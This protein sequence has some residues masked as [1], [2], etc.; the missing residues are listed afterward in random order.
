MIIKDF[1]KKLVFNSK[2]RLKFYYMIEKLSAD[3]VE[4][5]FY[6]IL[7]ELQQAELENN[8]NRKTLLYY[9][10]E[11]FIGWARS[12]KTIAECLQDYV[13]ETDVMMI[14]AFEEHDI[15]QGFRDLIAYNE[16]LLGMKKE[17]VAAIAYPAFLVVILIAIMAY[18]SIS[19]IPTLTQNMPESIQLSGVSQVLVLLSK[20]FFI[21]F[22]AICFFILFIIGFLLWALPNFNSALRVKLEGIPP[23]N[24]YR[25]NIGCGFLQSL[26]MLTKSGMQQAEAIETMAKLAAPY[27]AYRLGVIYSKVR[28]GRSLGEALVLS[29]L[30]F[31]DKKMVSDLSILSKHGVLENSLDKLADTM[32]R[33]GINTI[34]QQAVTLKTIAIACVAATIL[35]MF[36][37]VYSI[38]QDMTD[39][40]QNTTI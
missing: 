2:Q 35:F 9:V 30:N 22:P 21:W 14:T 3:D 17:F 28:D 34:K 12:G 24:M 33:D 23:F 13:P 20:N 37:G 11:D 38:S 36:A 10:Y 15:A 27:L 5:S 29:K 1:M 19:L 18:F 6:V 32:T 4:L 26:S 7:V 31:P 16:A 39:A 25:I 8:R 40:T